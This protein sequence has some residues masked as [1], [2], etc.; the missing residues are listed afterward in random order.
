MLMHSSA[1][2]CDCITK[3]EW[4]V[5][6]SHS[7]CDKQLEKLDTKGF[8]E[9]LACALQ[10]S[11]E[12][13]VVDLSRAEEAMLESRKRKRQI[14]ETKDSRGRAVRAKT[15][16]NAGGRGAGQQSQPPQADAVPGSDSQDQHMTSPPAGA[17]AASEASQPASTAA[18][19][20]APATA[21]AA[22]A[23]LGAPQMKVA[24]PA[25]QRSGDGKVFQVLALPIAEARGHTGYL[26][27]AR[28]L[29]EFTEP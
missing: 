15:N 28:R 21:S 9:C 22:T 5:S 27:F 16:G 4:R 18:A 14:K 23:E 24:A 29:V 2:S 12:K 20:A 13:M 7:T 25:E 10:V 6:E 3:E 8:C 17:A 11:N 19:A 1:L 26:T